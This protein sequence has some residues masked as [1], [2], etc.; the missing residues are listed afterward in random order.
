[1]PQKR[2]DAYETAQRLG[3]VPIIENDLVQEELDNFGTSQP[4]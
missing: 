4:I 1:M 2:G 3:H